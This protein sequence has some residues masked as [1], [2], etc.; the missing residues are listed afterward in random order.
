MPIHSYIKLGL[1]AIRLTCP[2]HSP[3]TDDDNK[4][5][6]PRIFLRTSY[7]RRYFQEDEDPYAPYATAK[8]SD[9]RAHKERWEERQVEKATEEREKQVEARRRWEELTEDVELERRRVPETCRAV[10]VADVAEVRREKRKLRRPHRNI[11]FP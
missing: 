4:I 3:D 6:L 2:H 10:D 1:F 8:Y 7:L 5:D 9:Y 11:W